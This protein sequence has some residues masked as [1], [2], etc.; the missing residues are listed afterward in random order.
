MSTADWQCDHARHVVRVI[1]VG[2]LDDRGHERGSRVQPYAGLRVV[3]DT[4]VPPIDAA[5]LGDEVPT[6]DEPILNELACPLRE[7]ARIFGG[8][9]QPHR[10]QAGRTPIV[11]LTQQLQLLC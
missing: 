5:S 7:P 2:T 1:P 8:S 11:V 3:M 9:G 10:P 6:G 4:A